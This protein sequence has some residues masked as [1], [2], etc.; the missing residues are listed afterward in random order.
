[1]TLEAKVRAYGLPQDAGNLRAL[2]AAGFSDVRLA[3]LAGRELE[4][5][6]AL[7]KQLGVLPVFKRIDTCAAEFAAPTAYMYST[8]EAPFAGRALRGGA[9]GAEEDRHSRRW[10]EPH[11]P[12]HRVR[13]LLLPRLFRAE[14]KPATKPS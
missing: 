8:Y 1:M 14:A 4:D 10:P 2:K 5:V 7:R 9:I 3:G 11:R 13:L 12:G 6:A